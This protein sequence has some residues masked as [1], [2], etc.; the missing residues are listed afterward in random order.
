MKKIILEKVTR[1]LKAK[2]RLEEIL[3]IKITNRGKEFYIEGK[4]INEYFAELVL[5]AFDFGFKLSEAILI[6]EQ[7][8]IF[9]ILNIKDYTK[10]H[11]LESIRARIIGKEGKTINTL[12]ELTK[13]AIEIRENNVGIIGSPETI[14]AAQ[15]GLIS[16]IQGSKQENVYS[17]LEK[18]HPEPVVDLGLKENFK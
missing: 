17:F 10:R 11:D 18:H 13:C 3:K 5:I 4:P 14:P 1:I 9:E 2:K 7:D 12:R 6:K 8:F 16:L 15:T